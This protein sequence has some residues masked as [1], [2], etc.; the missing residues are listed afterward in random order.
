MKT[1]RKSTGG[2]RSIRSIAL[3][4]LAAF[5]PALVGCED[6]GPTRQQ[7]VA[8]DKARA[9]AG[10]SIRTRAEE[11]RRAILEKKAG[12][13]EVADALTGYQSTWVL[14]RHGDEAFKRHTQ[15]LVEAELISEAWVTQLVGRQVAEFIIELRDIEDVLA[16]EAG[17]PALSVT[18]DHHHSAGGAPLDTEE[19]E[20]K[21]ALRMQVFTELAS[22]L[23]AEAATHL[24]LSSGILAGSSAFSWST[25]GISLGVGL[26][27]DVIV[28]WVMS[29][30]D[31]VARQLAQALEEAAL[32]QSSAY[33]EAMQQH[34]DERRERW[35]KE[36][37]HP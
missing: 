24:A 23:G 28:R 32:K 30:A 15:E 16:R 31:E 36:L 19:M 2:A 34:L 29:P 7:Q 4:A 26:A 17:C 1:Q 9:D 5:S 6:S 13:A 27:V 14:L 37:S 25:L 8:V 33:R 12:C 35:M 3:A 21:D 20:L 10:E 11:I 22:L 18:A